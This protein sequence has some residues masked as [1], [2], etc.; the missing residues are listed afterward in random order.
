MIIYNRQGHTKAK[1]K[2]NWGHQE[3]VY[4][5]LRLLVL[6]DLILFNCWLIECKQGKF[7]YSFMEMDVRFVLGSHGNSVCFA[8]L[9]LIINE[10]IVKLSCLRFFKTWNIHWFYFLFLRYIYQ[11]CI[12]VGGWQFVI[13]WIILMMRLCGTWSSNRGSLLLVWL[14][15]LPGHFPH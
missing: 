5:I 15:Q 14:I 4:E 7:N 6:V 3:V 13:S 2:L 12:D 10:W 8:S 9:T 1:S 11:R